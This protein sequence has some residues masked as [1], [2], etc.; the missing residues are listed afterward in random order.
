MEKIWE[1]STSVKYPTE[2]QEEVDKWLKKFYDNKLQPDYVVLLLNKMETLENEVKYIT[3][4]IYP[5]NC[6][7]E[8]GHAD[9]VREQS[10]I[11]D[12]MDKFLIKKPRD[13][14]N[15]NIIEKAFKIYELIIQNSL[16]YD[17]S[18]QRNEHKNIFDS[19]IVE[20]EKLANS[21]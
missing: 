10:R 7:E 12:I 8:F 2:I 1:E 6:N 18:G 9:R 17:I 20:L 21:Q 11:G 5:A 19:Y 4:D 15:V 13:E 14:E 3:A 16:L